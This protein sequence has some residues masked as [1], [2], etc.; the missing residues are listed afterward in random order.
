MTSDWRTTHCGRMDH[1][2]CKVQVQ[3]ID[4]QIGAI[5][6]DPSGYLNHGYT[7]PKGRA[8]TEVHDHPQRLRTP[9]LRTGQRGENK[10][11]S[12]DWD[13]ALDVV[14]TNLDQV[15]TRDGARSVAFC[16]G[17]PK[18]LEHFVLI[19]LANT[20]GSPNVVAVQDVC[21]APRELTGR[22]VCGF[23]PIPDMHHP[24]QLIL[25]WGSNS[26]ATNEEGVI[27]TCLT[28]RVR[29][30]AQLVVID[31]RRTDLARQ[32]D[33]WLPLRPGTDLALALGFLQVIIGEGLEEREFVDKW[34]VGFEELKAAA[35]SMS[36]DKIA[37]LTGIEQEKIQRAARA[38]ARARPACLAWGN[39]IEQVPETFDTIRS[40]ISLMAVCGNLDI[41]GGN[42][43]ASEPK[44]QPPGKFVR[45][46]LLPDKPTS[47]LNAAYGAS[48]RLMT[49]PSAFFR[50]A[51]LEEE[52]YAVRAA[53]MQ[54]TNPMLSYADVSLTREALLKLDFLAVSDIVMTP[55]AALADVV[56]P[57]ATHFEFD[58]IGHYGLGHGLI[59]AR[60]KLVE[61]PG[62][63]RPDMAILNDL[64]QRLCAQ[65]LWFDCH[66]QMLESLLAPSS[67][68][69]ES[70]A[71]QGMLKGINRWQHFE[72]KGFATPSGK[73]ELALSKAKSLGVEPVPVWAQSGNEPDDRFPLVLTSAKSPNYLHSSYRWVDSLRRREP[74]PLAQVNPDT[75]RRFNIKDGDRIRIETSSG[76]IVQHAEI[77]DQVQPGIVCAA[78]GWWF[79]ESGGHRPESWKT[80]NL[81]CLTSVQDLGRQ[82]GTPRLRGIP[83]RISLEEKDS[84]S[85]SPGT[86]NL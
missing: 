69:F 38:Y 57:A 54:C 43:K 35:F 51:V 80:A 84:S 17:M 4:G 40:L 77:T 2:G 53:Y 31:P 36:L 9:L 78:H 67:L 28:A 20:F 65:D 45:A 30:G 5:R 63:C 85:Q 1:G 55:T 29:E 79:P 22:H 23:Y 12:A 16:Q 18:G 11:R 24:T 52:P 75:A 37:G 47:I 42:I 81:N 86:D 60:P 73:V 10:W 48:P 49:V 58:D 19:R 76:S 74:R 82:Y 62:Q 27:N 66:E 32:A 39:A 71:A 61:P 33:I 64:G 13:E 21:H 34:T 46:D 8:L 50:R 14:A 56:L 68:D 15:R 26:R 72:D 70:F 44:T 3:V 7:C 6:G 41:P 25:L 83:C 59:L